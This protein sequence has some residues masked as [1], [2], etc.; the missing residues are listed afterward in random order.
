MGMC[1]W[2]GSC[3]VRAPTACQPEVYVVADMPCGVEVLQIQSRVATEVAILLH[4]NKFSRPFLEPSQNGYLET[5]H[6]HETK[7]IYK[8]S[9][10]NHEWEQ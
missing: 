6:S 5:S 10:P 9:T 2:P 8:L 4:P 7:E 1:V 3:F